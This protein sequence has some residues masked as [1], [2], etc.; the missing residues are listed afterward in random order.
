MLGSVRG[1]PGNWHS[2]RDHKFLSPNVVNLL[3][4]VAFSQQMLDAG[5]SLPDDLE[6]P[7]GEFQ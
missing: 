4:N 2:Y 7:D 3:E 1:V 5:Y 6:Y